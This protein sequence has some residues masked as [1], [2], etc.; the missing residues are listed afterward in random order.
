M[1]QVQE[2][3]RNGGVPNARVVPERGSQTLESPEDWWTIAMGSGLR[4][5]IDA[6][7]RDASERIRDNNV[8]WIRENG[9][10]SVEINVIY[11]TATKNSD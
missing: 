2:L 1:D 9:V 3:L 10:T 11:A 6:M 8:S 4:G 7:G 5:T